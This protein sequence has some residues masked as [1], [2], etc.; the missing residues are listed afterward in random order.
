MGGFPT[1]AELDQKEPLI[2]RT[3][4][5]LSGEGSGKSAI[6]NGRL[7]GI[8]RMRSEKRS[9]APKAE[10]TTADVARNSGLGS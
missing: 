8:A 2:V 4:R 3:A 1:N 7:F 9:I 6:G 10:P 5:A